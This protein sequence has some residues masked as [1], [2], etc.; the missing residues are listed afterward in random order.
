MNSPQCV[1]HTR[2]LSNRIDQL[3]YPRAKALDLPIGSGLIKSGHRHVLQ[4]R[5]KQPRAVWLRENAEVIA[6]MRVIRSNK[7]WEN[8]WN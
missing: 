1:L 5:L 7:Q 3:D 8:F 4:A 6:Q 2:Y